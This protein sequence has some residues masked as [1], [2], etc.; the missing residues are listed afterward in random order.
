MLTTGLC[1]MSGTAYR[2]KLL[3][4]KLMADSLCCCRHYTFYLWRKVFA[5]HWA[6]RY[7]LAPAYL[8][9]CCSLWHA[10]AAQRIRLLALGLALSTALTLVPAWL[11]E[12]R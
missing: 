4:C 9:S 12:F 2:V 7:A 5:R 10:L 11:I 8:F 6:V 1:T 3:P